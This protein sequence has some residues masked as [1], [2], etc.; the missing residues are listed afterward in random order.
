MGSS[1]WGSILRGCTLHL[2]QLLACL[3]DLLLFVTLHK[4]TLLFLKL[5]VELLNLILLKHLH[6]IL[7]G[8]DFFVL[9]FLLGLWLLLLFCLV[10]LLDHKVKACLDLSYLLILLLSDLLNDLLDSFLFLFGQLVHH[11]LALLPDLV[12]CGLLYLNLLLVLLFLSHKHI[13]LILIGLLKVRRLTIVPSWICYMVVVTSL[14]QAV[15]ISMGWSCLVSILS[16]RC[17]AVT[18]FVVVSSYSC[19]AV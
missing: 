5:F 16:G 19:L 10:Q 9:L 12:H 18:A 4:L 14:F 8:L 6:L 7:Y 11:Q 2:Y 17:V 13:L 3:L 1:G 15:C